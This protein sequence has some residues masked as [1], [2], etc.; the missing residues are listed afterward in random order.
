MYYQI[1]MNDT[2]KPKR[3][4]ADATR[5]AILQAAGKLFTEKGFSGTSI[6]EIAKGAN[7]NQ[8]LI[9]HHFDN[10]E[11]LWKAVK[12]IALSNAIDVSYLHDFNQYKTLKELIKH[13][14]E[15]RVLLYDNNPEL[16]RMIQWQLLEKDTEH[17]VGV[18]KNI[19]EFLDDWRAA[20]KRFKQNGEMRKDI[21][22]NTAILLMILMP[23]SFYIQHAW[24]LDRLPADEAQQVKQEYIKTVI[25]MLEQRLCV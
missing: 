16:L 9:Y 18:G 1:I 5:E 20:L 13:N 19:D 24:L 12:K 7:I 4:S 3:P 21:S 25:Q 14:I 10:K 23:S 2:D 15:N 8:S 17:L 11:G 22:E 6:C